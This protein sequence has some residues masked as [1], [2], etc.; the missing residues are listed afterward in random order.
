MMTWTPV[1]R[2]MRA[3]ACGS[4]PSVFGVGSTTVR[5]PAC[6]K[7]RISSWATC[8]SRSRRLSRLALKFWRTQPRFDRLTGSHARPLSLAAAG[9][10]NITLKSIRRCS[11]GRVTP[12][13][14]GATA[15]STVWICPASGPGMR[16][17]PR[18]SPSVRPRREPGHG[19]LARRLPE[20]GRDLG[21]KP[22]EVA[23]Q[24]V[25]RTEHARNED[26]V[27]PSGSELIELV[28][29]LVRRTGQAGVTGVGGV[30]AHALGDGVG[31]PLDLVL[32]VGDEQRHVDRALDGLRVATDRGAV[33]VEDLSFSR[34][35]AR[36]A[37][38]VPVIRVLGDDTQGDALA[39]AADHQL[40]VRRLDG[41]GI[42]R[43]VGELVVAPLEGGAPLGPQRPDH[44]TGL[45]QA[46]EP[47]AQRVEGDAV[48]LVLV[49]LPARAEAQQEAAAGND[50]DLRGHLRHHRRMAIR[51]TQHDGADAEAWHQG[52]QRTEGA[53][54]L[55]HGALALLRVRQE[56]VGDA[57]DVPPGRLEVPPEI[58]HARPSLAAHARE[59]T[60]AHIVLLF[61]FDLPVDSHT[62]A[63]GLVFPAALAY[64]A[65]G[66]SREP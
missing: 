57:G 25:Q 56:V 58:Q 47:L 19:D 35:D 21:A 10:A 41:L 5:P 48:G 29:N 22:I 34:R 14:S 64:R 28:A 2:A 31:E 52:R 60:E 33:L 37:P 43:G 12:I 16:G 44:L 30:A 23:T 49:L 1:A 6:L 62:I 46:L 40:G 38:D 39:P 63:T 4:R 54:R 61:G 17:S 42:E 15:P 53:P 20:R 11:C 3:S 36:T 45:V 26:R 65:L 32:S 9:S 27:D 59:Q 55:E 24:L 7:R 51:V 50:V 18:L 8:S 13:A 66:A